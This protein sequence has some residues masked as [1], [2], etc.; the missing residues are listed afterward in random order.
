MGEWGCGGVGVC[1]CVGQG[2]GALKWQAVRAAT[3]ALPYT[4][5][6]ELVMVQAITEWGW[7]FG[8]KLRCH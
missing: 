4:A 8:R 2:W 7:L 3:A 1:V 6:N 5:L